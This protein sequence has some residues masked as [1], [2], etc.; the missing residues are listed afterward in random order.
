[1]IPREALISALVAATSETHALAIVEALDEYLAEDPS[2]RVPAR[3]VLQPN[4]LIEIAKLR[5]ERD[6][7]IARAEKV[8]RKLRDTTRSR[9]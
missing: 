1:M 7:A 6:A 8:E 5:E 4:P 3:L 9:K 2:D